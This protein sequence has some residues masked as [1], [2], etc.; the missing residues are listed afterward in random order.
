MKTPAFFQRSELTATLW[1][2]RQ[3]FLMVGFF[4][5]LANVLMLSPTLYMLQVYDRVLASQSELTLLA[6]SLLTLALFGVMALA[7]WLRSRVLVRA[8]VRLDE[9]LGTQVFNASFESHLS[10]LGTS[11]ARSFG[12]LIQVR[13]FLTGNGI[14]AFFDAPWAPI[15]TAVL[16]M[17]HPWLG[18]LATQQWRVAAKALRLAERYPSLQASLA[19]AIATL[20]AGPERVLVRTLGRVPNT[21]IAV[22]TRTGGES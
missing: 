9:R 17:L 3:E 5:M 4:S 11:P 21:E 13:Q 14:F 15:Y 12:D 6:M 16:F 8:G 1:A 2:F 20:Q 19:A 18:V 10:L 7:E 22:F